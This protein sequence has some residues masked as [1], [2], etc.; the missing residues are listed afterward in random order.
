MIENVHFAYIKKYM[1]ILYIVQVAANYDAVLYYYNYQSN[2]T[3]RSL[4]RN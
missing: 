2:K 1:L 3:D 4:L